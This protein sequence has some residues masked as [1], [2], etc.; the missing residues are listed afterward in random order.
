MFGYGHAGIVAGGHGHAVDDAVA[1]SRAGAG[2]PLL[3][4]G[5]PVGVE[6]VLHH[7]DELGAGAA[8]GRV[9]LAVVAEHA[10]FDAPRD[11]AACPLGDLAPVGEGGQGRGEEG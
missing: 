8:V 1:V 7:R 6:D 4:A 9:D 2:L 3:A 5:R 11:G 10:V